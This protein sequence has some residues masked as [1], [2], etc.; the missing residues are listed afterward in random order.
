MEMEEGWTGWE[1]GT[2]KGK[3]F[4]EEKERGRGR[5]GREA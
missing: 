3:L 2:G 5:K 4:E 1:E